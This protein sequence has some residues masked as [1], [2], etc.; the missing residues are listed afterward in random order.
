L[1]AKRTFGYY[2]AWFAGSY[3]GFLINVALIV[4]AAVGKGRCIGQ[5]QSCFTSHTQWHKA[6]W[7]GEKSGATEMISMQT[8][9]KNTMQAASPLPDFDSGR[10]QF[11]MILLLHSFCSWYEQALN[12]KELQLRTQISP[13]IPRYFLGNQILPKHIFFELGQNSLLYIGRN[14]VLLEVTSKQ[15]AGRRYEIS[16]TITLFGG[17]IPANKEK[18][19]FQPSSRQPDT[20]G[21]RS[22]ST[23]LYYARMIARVLGGDIRIDNKLGSGTR[24]EVNLRLLSISD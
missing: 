5:P 11:D 17:G 10:Q 23:N 3:P 22:R 7:S 2:G 6:I 1:S 18:E 19:L 16:F 13:E 4:P 24:Y 20:E 14:E 21:F 15:L 8:Y 9:M 12:K